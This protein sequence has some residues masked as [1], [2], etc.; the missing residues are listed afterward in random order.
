MFAES[1]LAGE[2]RRQ[3]LSDR[4]ADAE[5][6][7][8]SG[9]D[10][11]SDR[12]S[13]HERDRPRRCQ[14]RYAA[15]AQ[16]G[17][18]PERRQ[19]NLP[20][21][22]S[23]P[24][25]GERRPEPIRPIRPCRSATLRSRSVRARAATDQRAQFRRVEVWFI[26]ERRRQTLGVRSGA[27]ARE[28]NQ[29]EGLPQV[30][31]ALLNTNRPPVRSLERGA[32]SISAGADYKPVFVPLRAIAIRLGRSITG[33][34]RSVATYPEVVTERAAP[35]PLFGLAPRGVC[36]ASRIAPAAVRF[37]R[38]ISPLPDR[39]LQTARRYIFCGTFRKD[40]F[41]RS[42]PAVSRHVALWRPDFPPAC[43]SGYPSCTCQCSVSHG[44][45]MLSVTTRTPMTVAEFEK[46]PDDGNLHELDEGELI[47]MPPPGL[48]HGIVQAA[49][50][51]R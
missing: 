42:P 5:A 15:R 22:R 16:H 32:F 11:D 3:A 41:E 49:V 51:A 43:A 46:L 48:R 30:V 6:A 12:P 28:G 38:T 17:R 8:R 35:P 1:Q 27:C 7:R 29:G 14:S 50:A 13:R 40:P 34:T 21:A 23:Q 9:F 39:L 45:T 18:G 37:Y 47:V 2:Q 33:A 4:T 36:P 10:G 20:R 26:P 24:R 44:R 25:A 31:S 19:G